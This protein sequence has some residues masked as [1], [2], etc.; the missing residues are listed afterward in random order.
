M[1]SIQYYLTLCGNYLAFFFYVEELGHKHH[2]LFE[3]IPNGPKI[4]QMML[5]FSRKQVFEKLK[6][7]FPVL[8]MLT[9]TGFVM[10]YLNFQYA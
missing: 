6:Q 9:I 4:N 8:L 3:V 7:Q 5:L 1:I 2:F 10:S